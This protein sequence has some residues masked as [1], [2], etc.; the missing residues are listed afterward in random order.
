MSKEKQKSKMD[1]SLKQDEID[2][3]LLGTDEDCEPITEVKMPPLEILSKDEIDALLTSISTE[4]ISKYGKEPK[5][6]INSDLEKKS[7]KDLIHI[8]N[9]LYETAD[10]NYK[11]IHKNDNEHDRL[12]SVLNK[13]NYQLRDDLHYI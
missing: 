5:K 3:L 6:Y 1:G 4:S 9:S 10:I 2:A 7:K 13:E 8:V 12:T 11:T